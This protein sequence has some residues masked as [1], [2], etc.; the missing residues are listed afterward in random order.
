MD[1]EYGYVMRAMKGGNTTGV[2][3]EYVAAYGSE[4]GMKTLI[5]RMVRKTGTA[6]SVR[7]QKLFTGI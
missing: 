7:C 4:I 3:T 5:A 6:D 2:D 1:I